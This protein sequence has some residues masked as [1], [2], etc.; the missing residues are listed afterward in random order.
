MNRNL[1]KYIA[2]ML[3]LAMLLCL[4]ACGKKVAEAPSDPNRI[5]IG[6]YEVLYQKSEIMK[7]EDGTDVVVFIGQ[8]TNNS[9]AVACYAWNVYEK[10]Y[11][12][13]T[14]LDAAVIFLSEESYEALNDS[15]FT[16]IQPGN[17]LEIKS[18]YKLRDREHPVQIQYSDLMDKYTAELTIDLAD[19]E[20]IEENEEGDSEAES[21]DG[22]DTLDSLWE[23]DDGIGMD[24]AGVWT[25]QEIRDLAEANGDICSAILLGYSTDISSLLTE[26]DLTDCPFI[27]EIPKENYIELTDGGTEIYCIIPTDPSASLA[28]NEWIMDE[29]NGFYGETGQVLYRSESGDPILLRA[30]PSDVVPSTQVVIV[31]SAGESLDWNPS[32]SLYDGKMQ[33]PWYSPGVTDLTDYGD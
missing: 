8:F 31:D 19:A 23:P 21:G 18:A 3:S 1:K 26:M 13:G 15:Q 12:D 29:T 30:N 24:G 16:E 11:Q 28:V 4:G 2:I 7:D 33:I 6:D 14:E 20:L 10:V 27:Q 17:S 32:V 9:K 25:L 22:E 5:V